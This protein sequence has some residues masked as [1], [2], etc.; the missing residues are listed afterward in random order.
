MVACGHASEISRVRSPTALNML[1]VVLLAK[2]LCSHVHS[3]DP[4]VNVYLVGQ[5]R[6]VCLNSSVRRKWQPACMLPGGVEMA[7][8]RTGPVTKG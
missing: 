7:H 2:A 4:L 6:L 3:L 8:E 5:R 1:R